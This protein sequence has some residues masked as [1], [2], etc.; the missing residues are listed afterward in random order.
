MG[1]GLGAGVQTCAVPISTGA[2]YA[3]APQTVPSFSINTQIDTWTKPKDAGAPLAPV[4]NGSTVYYTQQTYATVTGF[5][6]IELTGRK[7]NPFLAQFFV[8]RDSSGNRYSVSAVTDFRYR[9]NSFDMIG[10]TPWA[11]INGDWYRSMGNAL[12]LGTWPISFRQDFN[13]HP[14][15]DD[16]MERYLPT[17]GA[18]RLELAGTLPSGASGGSLTV[19]TLDLIPQGPIPYALA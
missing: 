5:N 10:P 12:E 15:G 14:A 18:T 9:V 6:T 16:T 4:G 2:V 7:G 8:F 11:K 1:D 17:S 3:T 13:D 19:Y